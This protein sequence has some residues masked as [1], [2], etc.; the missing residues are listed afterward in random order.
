MSDIVSQHA[1]TLRSM[2]QHHDRFI[3]AHRGS[4]GTAPENTM[5]SIRSAIEAGALMVEVDVQLTKDDQVVLMHDPVLGR[6][7][8]G[9][10]YI[11]TKTLQELQTLDAG[12]W[13]NAQFSGEHIP[14]LSEALGYL[15]QHKTCVNIEIKPPQKED[16]HISRLL[17]IIESVQTLNMQEVTLFSSFHHESLHYIKKHYPTFHTAGIHLPNDKRLPSNI[18]SEIG[19]EGFVCSLRELTHAKADDA[20]KHDILL[21]VYTINDESDFHKILQYP[22]PA[23]VSNFPKTIKEFLQ[24]LA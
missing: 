2:I 7:T 9:K 19:C 15:K 16:D 5:S 18:A 22:V 14:L 20:E 1:Y 6:T 13:F 24:H 21:G 11:R 3:V 12:T 8:N 23:L 4:S 10:G 17:A